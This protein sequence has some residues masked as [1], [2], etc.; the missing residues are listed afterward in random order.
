MKIADL[1]ENRASVNALALEAFL[2]GKVGVMDGKYY[3]VCG[4]ISQAFGPFPTSGVAMLEGYARS[5]AWQTLEQ[6]RPK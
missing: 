3:Y 1:I 5:C 4:R 2:F 6:V